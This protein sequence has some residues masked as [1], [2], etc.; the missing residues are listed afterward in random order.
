MQV[1]DNSNNTLP[2]LLFILVNCQAF[3]SGDYVVL[4]SFILCTASTTTATVIN[5]VFCAISLG[6]KSNV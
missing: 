3:L 5:Q 4:R 2:H 1:N 6:C